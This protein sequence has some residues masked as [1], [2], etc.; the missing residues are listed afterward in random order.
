M[1]ADR[2]F[3]ATGTYRFPSG[4]RQTKKAKQPCGRD[5]CE[6]SRRGFVCCG[7]RPDKAAIVLV[8][9]R[10]KREVSREEFGMIVRNAA[11]EEME[12]RRRL[13]VLQM[14]EQFR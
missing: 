4:P 8:T 6:G 11:R 10:G 3:G 13:R 7:H 2:E 1:M 9:P 14:M 12:R 5:G